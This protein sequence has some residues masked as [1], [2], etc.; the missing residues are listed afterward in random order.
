MGEEFR[1][2]GGASH[3]SGKK[4]A[5]DFLASLAAVDRLGS[6]SLNERLLRFNKLDRFS[7]AGSV[8]YVLPDGKI[9]VDKVPAE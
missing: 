4:G 9:L 7:E 3:T 1:P 6:T 5:A 8:Q 2:S